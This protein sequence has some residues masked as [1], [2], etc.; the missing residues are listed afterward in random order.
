MQWP[1]RLTWPGPGFAP[2]HAPFI[3]LLLE[4]R[5]RFYSLAAVYVTRIIQA[6]G[7][8]HLVLVLVVVLVLVSVLL[9]D[10]VALCF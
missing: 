3:L 7:L 6:P 2:L 4:S 1:G 10:A 8:V 5:Q 9:L